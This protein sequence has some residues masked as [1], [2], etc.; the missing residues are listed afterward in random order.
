M[1]NF[2]WLCHKLRSHRLARPC[3]ASTGAHLSADSRHMGQLLQYPAPAQH[4]LFPLTSVKMMILEH[5]ILTTQTNYY[6]VWPSYQESRWSR[7]HSQGN[8]TTTFKL[9]DFRKCLGS[10]SN[11]LNQFRLHKYIVRGS[12]TWIHRLLLLWS[13]RTMLPLKGACMLSGEVILRVP[14]WVTSMVSLHFL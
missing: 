9:G 8:D 1:M 4:D 7:T 14:L 5:V 13:A 10:S 2:S 12:R 6:E 11:F 3:W